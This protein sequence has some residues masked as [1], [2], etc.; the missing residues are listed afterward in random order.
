MYC[1]TRAL[2]GS[3]RIDELVAPQRV[4]LDVDRKAALAV[5]DQVRRLRH[6]KR[7]RDE[8]D[9]IGAHHAVLL[10]TVVPSTIGRMSR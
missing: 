5:L 7:T 2:R 9:V 4:E 6:M 3:V 1:L 8:Q 10:F